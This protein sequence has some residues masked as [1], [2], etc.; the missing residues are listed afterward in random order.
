MHRF[1]G[2]SGIVLD[3]I[4]FGG[5]SGDNQ[6]IS[7]RPDGA[8]T[9]SI[10][11]FTEVLNNALDVRLRQDPDLV[12]KVATLPGLALLKLIAWDDAYPDR[13]RDAMD[14]FAI[15]NYYIEAGNLDR[16]SSDGRDLVGEPPQPRHVL[17]ATSSVGIWRS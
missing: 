10:A 4:P 13:S 17:G 9:M 8:R 14:C 7:W 12:V 16:L 3:V 11:G 5:I 6:T 15:M 2:S 1:V